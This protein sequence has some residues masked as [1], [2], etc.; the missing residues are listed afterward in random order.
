V[1]SSILPRTDNSELSAKATEAN[2]LIK[3]ICSKNQWAFIDHKSV[4][5]SCQNRRGL[6]LNRKGTSVV[7]K[8]IFKYI[9]S[10]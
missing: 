3:A 4:N 5:F 2:K 6:H 9:S 10:C 8:D 7:A 1:I